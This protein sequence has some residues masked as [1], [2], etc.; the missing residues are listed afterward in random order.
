MENN[1]TN[2][3]ILI[4]GDMHFKDNLSY[5]DYVQDRRIPEKKA[6]L[7]FIVD[8]SSDCSAIVFMG[9][10]MN[11]KNNSAKSIREFIEFVERFDDKKVYIILGNHE[12]KGDGSSALDFMEEINKPN[13]TIVTRKP[14]TVDGGYTFLPYMSNSE[15]GCS[16][17][18]GSL[19]KILPELSGG[20]YLF[21][22]HA[23]SDTFAQDG[24][25]VND[26]KEMILPK[27]E[28]ESRYS[29]IIAGHVHYP[30][31]IGRTIITGS[32]FTDACGDHEKF[33]WKINPLNDE[34]EKLKVPGRGIYKIIN[35]TAGKLEK[36][37]KDSIV[38]CVITDKAIDIEKIKMMLSEY[39]AYILIEQYPNERKKLHF[40]DGGSMDFTIEQ[41][42]SAYSKEKNIDYKKLIEGYEIIK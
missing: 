26:F 12:K 2:N 13:W 17:S 35:P 15:L 20:T 29:M 6:I 16:T 23:I 5:A 19:E 11:S 25:N 1:K 34:V 33:I 28:L 42:L 40:D 32:T 4:L 38:K 39:D 3:K 7:D 8:S 27:E 10:N 21:A 18:K 9:D 22:H 14:L 36:I 31:Q 24:V 30:Q 41:L 37:S